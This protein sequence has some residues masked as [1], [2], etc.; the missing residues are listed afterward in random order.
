MP[1]A[2]KKQT[3]T[4]LREELAACLAE[5]E[6]GTTHGTGN[7]E[8]AAGPGVLAVQAYLA[9]KREMARLSPKD[10][11]EFGVFCELPFH[12]AL[13]LV[14]K[15][16]WEWYVSQR[17][18][19]GKTLEEIV[20]EGLQAIRRVSAGF[21]MTLER[22]ANG[23]TL[24]RLFEEHGS[25]AS[26]SGYDEKDFYDLVR[27]MVLADIHLFA[28]RSPELDNFIAGEEAQRAILK[29]V[30]PESADEFWT[31]KRVWIELEN[32]VG[33]LLLK[34]EKQ[35]LRNRKTHR[36]WMATFGHVYIPLV[37]SEYRYTSL[38]YRIRCKEDD[39]S[40]TLE[41]L[42]E[43]EEESR[44]AEAEH[45]ARLRKDARV[46][47][48]ELPG[49]GGIPLD[50][51]EMD[52]YEKECKKLLRKIWRLTHPDNIEREKFTAAQKKKLRAYFEEA[53]PYQQ[54][55]MLDDE[56]IALS[57]RS[58]MALR[59]LLAKVEAV[60]NSMGLDCN[61]HAVI[62]GDTLEEQIVW[63]D[64]RIGALEEEA[65]EVRAGLMAAV[66][67]PETL[68]MEACL[69]SAEQIARINEEMSAKLEWYEEQ[70]R[71]LEN[72]LAEL[73]A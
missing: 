57:M 15:G 43:L 10:F 20:G 12:Q 4:L 7:A 44:L 52:D 62:Q 58:L 54:G 55:G 16:E 27:H 63:L 61:E 5:R 40:L 68:E 14:V 30:A 69:A 11:V 64:A 2:S 49:P 48:K 65:G 33:G 21:G 34:L 36:Q 1:S 6:A 19:E 39:P 47:K 28:G 46:G 41:A 23:A 37:E 29:G 59:D 26:K 67:D 31:K 50:D 71:H 32:E 72:R 17:L 35:T 45:L 13:S 56:E 66:N 51:E 24:Y 38:T 70:S 53:V 18:P 22:A 9:G 3:I 8:H 73:F 42:E 60:W 25:L